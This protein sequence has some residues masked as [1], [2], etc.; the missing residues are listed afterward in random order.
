MDE[1]IG[2]WTMV[3]FAIHHCMRPGSAILVNIVELTTSSRPRS[4]SVPFYVYCTCTVAVR[5]A[6]DISM[7]GSRAPVKTDID[8][9]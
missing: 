8:Q 1:S 2:D 9:S 6:F 3:A 4:P 5:L 7:S